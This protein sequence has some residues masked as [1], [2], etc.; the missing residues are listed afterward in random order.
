ML[1]NSETD[2]L[3]YEFVSSFIIKF[4]SLKWKLNNKL[5]FFSHH[6]LFVNKMRNNV[7]ILQGFFL[8]IIKF[9]S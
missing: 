3:D 5:F 6:E 4:V 1:L 8:I 2:L 9:V 7:S